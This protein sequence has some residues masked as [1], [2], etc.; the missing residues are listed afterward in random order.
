MAIL[1]VNEEWIVHK[2]FNSNLVSPYTHTTELMIISM[3]KRVIT[4]KGIVTNIKKKPDI[5]FYIVKNDKEILKRDWT[6]EMRKSA[7]QYIRDYPIL[8]SGMKPTLLGK[9]LFTITILG[10]S[11]AFIAI[12]YIILFLP[13]VQ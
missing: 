7:N 10:L 9:I 4:V 11:A 12:G 6:V 5:T 13:P 1:F 2:E 3:Y 8:N